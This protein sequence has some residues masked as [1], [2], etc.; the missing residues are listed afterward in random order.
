MWKRD[1]ESV[2]Y[3]GSKFLKDLQVAKNFSQTRTFYFVSFRDFQWKWTS[4]PLKFAFSVALGINKSDFTFLGGRW[5]GCCWRNGRMDTFIGGMA[6]YVSKINHTVEWSFFWRR[7]FMEFATKIRWNGWIGYPG[8]SPLFDI[9][10][11]HFW[12]FHFRMQTLSTIHTW[13]SW[14]LLQILDSFSNTSN[15]TSLHR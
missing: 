13:R 1:S 4:M 15:E 11:I 7:W 14:C 5:I 10:K 6:E 8:I 9:L 12:S 3:L 2:N